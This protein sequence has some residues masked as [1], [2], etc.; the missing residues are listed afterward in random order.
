EER[1]DKLVM[2]RLGRNGF[3]C[4]RPGFAHGG[5]DWKDL[6]LASGAAWAVVRSRRASDTGERAARTRS[7]RGK[8]AGA[9]LEGSRSTV[10]RSEPSP[11]RP[12][13]NPDP[14]YRIPLGVTF[15]ESATKNPAPSRAPAAANSVNGGCNS[16]LQPADQA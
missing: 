12:R 13:Q 14:C 3:G 2:A 4:G 6:P 16:V 10:H 9:D 5:V 8:R 1:L 11:R 7:V 15:F